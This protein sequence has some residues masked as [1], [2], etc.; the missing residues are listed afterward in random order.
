MRGTWPYRTFIRLI[1]TPVILH[2]KVFRLN[3][4]CANVNAI[5]Y[6]VLAFTFAQNKFS[7][8]TLMCK[9]AGRNYSLGG[10]I[11]VVF[12]PHISTIHI[13][14]ARSRRRTL[15]HRRY[16][17]LVTCHVLTAYIDYWGLQEKYKKWIKKRRIFVVDLVFHLCTWGEHDLY[18]TF[19]RLISTP[20]I[21]ALNKT[22]ILNEWQSFA[23]D[24]GSKNCKCL[25]SFRPCQQHRLWNNT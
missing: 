4:F 13:W 9:I 10:D 2:I 20:V 15:R 17:S 8:N 16:G 14:N 22:L 25:D 19:I 12:V 7:L 21:Y 23:A 3:L 18:R 11:S 24:S 5:C 1:F 6:S